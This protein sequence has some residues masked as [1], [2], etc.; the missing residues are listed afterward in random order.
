MTIK[1]FPH[2]PLPRFKTIEE[3]NEWARRLVTTL[4]EDSTL[5]VRDIQGEIDIHTHAASDIDSGT[6]VHERGGLEA[7]VS[8]YA[9]L[10]KISG[11][12]TSQVTDGSTNWNT[13]YT[14]SGLTSGNPHSVTKSD[15]GLGSVEDT[16]LS[17]WVG[18]S[19]I[20]TLGTIG[21]GTWN[22]S[23]IDFTYLTSTSQARAYLNTEQED[24]TSGSWT[25]INLDAESYDIGGNYD[26]DGGGYDYTA[27]VTGYYIVCYGI[28]W[29]DCVADKAYMGGIYV[30]GSIVSRT[31]QHTS[32][33]NDISCVGSDILYLTLND[34]VEL[35]GRQASGVDTVDVLNGTEKT[36][37]SIHLLST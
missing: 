3:A 35:W 4:Q 23:D 31:I 17:T 20:T 8:G 32:H 9:G 21:A 16:A 19:N 22:G 24:F 30:N 2:Y 6:L 18:T 27:P 26:H 12:S 37:M 33:A 1:R 11:G 15:V 28:Q 10:L 5:R 25:Q 34:S 7:D 13:A 14:H 36:F 29:D